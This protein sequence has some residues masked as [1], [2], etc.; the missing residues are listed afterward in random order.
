MI[1]VG[2]VYG[3][4]GDNAVALGL[5]RLRDTQVP[6]GASSTSVTLGTHFRDTVT[7]VALRASAADSSATVFETLASQAEIRRQSVNGVSTD[8]E[9]IQLMRHQQ[10]YV[11]ATRLVSTVDE[12]AQALLGMV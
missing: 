8:E 10:A 12:M 5:S 3:G 1:A 7:D 4:T 11:A 9:L 6:V 2:S